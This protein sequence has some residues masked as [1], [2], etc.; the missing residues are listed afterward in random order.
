MEFSPDKQLMYEVQTNLIQLQ[1]ELK[2]LEIQQ[3]LVDSYDQKSAFLT[4]TAGVG[5]IHAEDWTSTLFR[6]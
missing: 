4:I 1:K 3:L 6:M 5:G 2:T